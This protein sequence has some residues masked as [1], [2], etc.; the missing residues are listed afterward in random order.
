MA[1]PLIPPPADR[2]QR[3]APLSEHLQLGAVLGI[4]FPTVAKM[5]A[6]GAAAA[7]A[8]GD[9][10]R[11]AL[12]QPPSF[13]AGVGGP[14]GPAAEDEAARPEAASASTAAAPR[15]TDREVTGFDGPFEEAVEQ[16]LVPKPPNLQWGAWMKWRQTY[17]ALPSWEVDGG[18]V[19]Q[20]AEGLI[21]HR[22]LAHY[23]GPGHKNSCYK[24]W[25]VPAGVMNADGSAVAAADAVAGTAAYQGPPR[26]PQ[27]PPPP[28]AI[29]LV[30]TAARPPMDVTPSD[31]VFRANLDAGDVEAGLGEAFEEAWYDDWHEEGWGEGYTW[32][33]NG[34]SD[35]SEATLLVKL[36][37]EYD[38]SSEPMS[39]Y[40]QR[41]KHYCAVAEAFHFQYDVD[42]TIRLMH[43]AEFRGLV[44]GMEPQEQIQMLK[45]TAWD[46][47]GLE[48][49]PGSDEHLQ[50][51]ARAE[52]LMKVLAEFGV[53]PSGS[54]EKLFSNPNSP[55]KASV[56]DDLM[57]VSPDT[58]EPSR[59]SGAAKL[60]PRRTSTC[61]AKDRG[62][63]CGGSVPRAR[64]PSDASY[65]VAPA[66]RAPGYARSNRS[67]SSRRSPRSRRHRDEPVG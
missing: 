34:D 25:P 49:P 42:Y 60:P 14:V 11:T 47:M 29:P 17:G 20:K 33:D 45:C 54:L 18:R 50:Y 19:R 40:F 12:A 1:L 31:G 13:A 26:P 46:L 15:F 6:T 48:P 55:A 28:H 59:G 24:E 51:Q 36:T 22:V 58:V 8:A 16:G 5:E 3:S 67:P 53:R 38:P 2:A 61:S 65:V 30:G 23:Y 27:T 43:R 4:L 66:V 64:F 52:S 37:Q 35:V 21:Y 7:A 10:P 9:A 63:R 32:S 57:D 62:W 44:H 39:S 56:G 41:I